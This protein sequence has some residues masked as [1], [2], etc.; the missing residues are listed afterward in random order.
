MQTQQTQWQTLQTEQDYDRALARLWQIFDSEPGTPEDAE[1]DLLVEL[2]LAYEDIHYPIPLPTPPG[3]PRILDRPMAS[4]PRRPGP[5]HRQQRTDRRHPRRPAGNH[6]PNRRRPPP[7][8]QHR[9]PRPPPPTRGYQPLT[10][11]PDHRNPTGVGISP[12]QL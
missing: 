7:K 12:N 11:A 2:I 1:H 4:H 9:P 8:T 5:G 10:P 6:P 3:R